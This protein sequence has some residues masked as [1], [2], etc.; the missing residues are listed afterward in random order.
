VTS[1]QDLGSD[2]L[3]Q[4]VTN[5]FCTV[6]INR[7]SLLSAKFLQFYTIQHSIR[8]FDCEYAGRDFNQNVDKVDPKDSIININ[9]DKNLNF[10]SKY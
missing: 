2:E 7:D 1:S 9:Y 6:Q 5:Y 8:Y 4:E 10:H 3:L